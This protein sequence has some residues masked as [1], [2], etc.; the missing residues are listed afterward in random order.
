MAGGILMGGEFRGM[1]G[2]R[3][4]AVL[5]V[6]LGPEAAA[7]VYRHLDEATIEMLT[8]E[9]AAVR[10][11]D[12]EERE[13]VLKEVKEILMAKEFLGRGGV[14]Y[15]RELLEQSMGREKAEELLRKL[16]SSLQTKPFDFLRASDPVQLF[17]FLQGEH[18]QMI[19][20]ILSFLP[21]DRAATVLGG[22]PPEAQADVAL[23]IA[24]MDRVTPEVLRETEKVLEKKMSAVM[25]ADFSLAGGVDAVVQILN[26]SGRKT[27]KNNL[28]ILD[29]R[30]PELAEE[31]RKKLFTFEDILRIDDR[32]LQKALRDVD[33][34]EMAL[35][36]KGVSENLKEKFFRNMSSRAVEMLKEEMELLGPVRLRD[37]EEA[38]QKIVNRIRSLEEA[39]EILFTG[40]GEDVVL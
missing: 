28:E 33:G 8:L 6:L 38:Q 4:A 10:R 27:E 20:L 36:L 3:K 37:V 34:K 18:P 25:G 19:A 22:L 7:Q 21:A 24:N 32:S 35:A 2:R 23:R 39:G 9:I 16:T 13:A 5:L 1:K 15:A 31:I 30:D 11:V 14:A 29:E 12:P 40:G 26:K 17:S